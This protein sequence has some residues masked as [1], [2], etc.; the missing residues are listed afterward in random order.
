MNIKDLRAGDLVM[1]NQERYDQQ[2]VK[3]YGIA[4]VLGFFTTSPDHVLI[5]FVNGTSERRNGNEEFLWG[6]DF[7]RS[8]P[9]EEILASPLMKYKLRDDDLV[10]VASTKKL[11]GGLL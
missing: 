4:R 2:L 1:L 6:M 5:E 7:E 9:R 8:L 11:D 10:Y 3:E